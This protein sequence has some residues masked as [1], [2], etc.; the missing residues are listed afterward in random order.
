M[1]EQIL[2]F[3]QDDNFF[4]VILR[5]AVTKNLLSQPCLLSRHPEER[6]DE[7]SASAL[8]FWLS[9]F[10]FRRSLSAAR[11]R[12]E[13]CRLTAFYG[14]VGRALLGGMSRRRCLPSNSIVSHAS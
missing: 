13:S 3:A 10:S 4:S 5:S 7:G 8:S 2:R 12:A 1:P 9:V 14:L 11:L 6:S